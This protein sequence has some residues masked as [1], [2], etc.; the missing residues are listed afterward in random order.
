MKIIGE[1]TGE[2]FICQISKAEIEKVLGL[3]YGKMPRVKVGD[4]I[5]LGDGYDYKNDIQRACQSM[6]DTM[7]NFERC[8]S[9]LSNFANMIVLQSSAEG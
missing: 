5:N 2:E 1:I 3:Y 8:R 6:E 7:K 9:T 4:S